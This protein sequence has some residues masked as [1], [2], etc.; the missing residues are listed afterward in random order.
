MKDIAVILPVYNAHKTIK[1]TIASLVNQ[2]GVS[3]AIYLSVDG[4]KEGSYD[5]I[6]EFFNDT[7]ITIFYIPTNGG[8][9]MARQYG[10]DH[11]SEPFITFV[12]SDDLLN[13][14]AALFTLKNAFK[15]NISVIVSP[16]WK[17]TEDLNFEFKTETLTWMHGKMYRRSF[18]DK[19]KIRFNKEHTSSNEDLGFN[20][21]VL[22][23]MNKDHQVVMVQTP[24]YLWLENPNS[25]VRRNNKE[26]SHT[27]SVDGFINNKI[28]AI[29]HVVETL[30]MLDE[31]MKRSIVR[32]L[33][34]IF[35]NYYGIFLDKPDYV[36]RFTK[37]SKL[38]YKE[39]YHY[40][41]GLKN[42]SI[43]EKEVLK[44]DKK[45]YEDYKKWKK[46]LKEE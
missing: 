25:I 28:Y 18:L 24:V 37:L 23:V 6:K 32:S 14:T 5:Y 11:T 30:N 1:K 2:Y 31:D 12:D 38:F 42:I 45:S 16:F 3:Y 8:P 36:E 10:I 34:S 15:D 26:F 21:I 9:G 43:F 20:S 35:K 7:D 40:T 29:K 44:S 41:K 27:T 39:V 4:E 33:C 22:D 17:Q 46:T 13:N 19:Y